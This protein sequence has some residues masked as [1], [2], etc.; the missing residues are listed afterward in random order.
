MAPEILNS[1]KSSDFVEGEFF[2][3]SKLDIF[4]LGL[5]T[6]YAVDRDQFLIRKKKLNVDEACLKSYLSV[7]RIEEVN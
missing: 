2:I 5:I 6:L 3:G 7:D 4:S 1:L